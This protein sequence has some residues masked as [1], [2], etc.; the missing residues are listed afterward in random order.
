MRIRSDVTS[1]QIVDLREG[2]TTIG[3]SPR[4]DIRIQQPGVQPLHCL[5]L[6]EGDNL[7]V[8]RWAAGTR[9]NGQP[10]D[11]ARIAPGDCLTVGE[12]ELRIECP[13]FAS[14]KVE[15]EPCSDAG[16]QTSVE[17]RA[18]TPEAS[19]A[20][21]SWG[22]WSSTR[23]TVLSAE[24]QNDAVQEWKGAD[25]DPSEPQTGWQEQW[26]KQPDVGQP[27][28]SRLTGLQEQL[29]QLEEKVA[30]W[31]EAREAWQQE[32]AEWRAERQQTQRLW[33]D[34]QQQLVEVQL[35]ADEIAAR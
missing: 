28:N 19:P 6:C 12:A 3:S 25:C 22:E 30:L 32:K 5:I 26:G 24:R 7:S 27:S 10:F 20:A 1:Q 15:K 4:C 14:A 18:A 29:V 9:L 17:S 33:T 16:A 21:D 2:K 8:R 13:Q 11:E 31:K 34:F 23:Q 35:R